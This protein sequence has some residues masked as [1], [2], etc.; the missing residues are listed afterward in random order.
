M[1]ASVKAYGHEGSG[2]GELRSDAQGPGRR[3]ASE[4]ARR[5]DRRAHTRARRE[6]RRE[7]LAQRLDGE[8]R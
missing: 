1:G 2:Q 7:A 3:G 4:L 6:G 5:V 8:G